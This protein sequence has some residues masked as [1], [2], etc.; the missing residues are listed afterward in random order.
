MLSSTAIIV[1]LFLIPLAVLIIYHDV[2][3]RRIPN[4]IVLA[5]LLRQQRA[6]LL[7]VNSKQFS[8]HRM[9]SPTTIIVALFLIPLAVLILYHDVRYRRIPN[10][11]ELATL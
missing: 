1:E 6:T 9:P 8:F 10:P 7:P 3:Y 11:I 5:T 4:P 2:R